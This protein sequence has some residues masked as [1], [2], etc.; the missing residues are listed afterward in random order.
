MIEHRNAVHLAHSRIMRLG[1]TRD[2]RVTQFASLGFDASVLEIAMALT[3]GAALYLPTAEQRESP[4]AFVA[5][6]NREAITHTVLPPAFLQGQT[7]ALLGHPTVILGGEAPSIGLIRSLAAQARVIN[8]YGPTE[9]T[10]C[11]TAW[12]APADAS[13]LDC[14][15]I[16]RPL[17]NTRLYLLDEAQ[18]PVALGETGELYIGGDG[19]A[20]GYLHRPQL[21]AERFL[22]D[23][24]SPHDGARMYRSGDLARYLA[25]G[26]LVFAGRNDDQIKLR[27]YRIELGEIEAR[28]SEHPAVTECA[29][30]AREDR[31]GDACLIAYYLASDAG[32]SEAV[33]AHLRVYLRERLPAYM[34]PAAF[35]A[36]D[37][38]P[39]TA[40]GKIDRKAL[41]APQ[42]RDFARSA[43]EAPEG[44]TEI[45]LATL[46]QDVLGVERVGRHDDF[47]VLGG[48]SLTAVRLLSRVREHF[49]TAP[50][51]ATLFAQPV[52]ADWAQTFDAHR[53][54]P[55]PHDP[56]L[57][58]LPDI[59]PTRHDSELPMSFAQQRLWFLSRMDGVSESY[60]MPLA[61]ELHGELDHA[62]LQR[63]LDRVFA[64]HEGLRTVFRTVCGNPQAGLLPAD[65]GLPM[66]EHDLREAHDPQGELARLCALDVRTPFDLAQGPAIR[67][68]LI[69]LGEREH[70]LAITQHHIVCDGWSMHL[71]AREIGQLY[72]AFREQRPDPLPPLRVQ[73]PDYAAWEQ[74]WQTRERLASQAEYWRGAL[75][76]APALLALP[77][78]R[79][80]PPRQSFAAAA[81]PIRLDREL[82][83]QLKRL[84]QTQGATLFMT[85]MAAWA[86]VLA[87][88]SGQDDLVIGT[89]SANRGRRE[90]EPLIGFF[91]NTLAL[92]VDLSGDPDVAQLLTQMR[93]T[94]LAAQAHQDL[95]FEQVVEIVQPARRMDHTPLFQVLFAWQNNEET[96][97]DLPG[98]RVEARQPVEAVRFDLE[99]HLHER[100]GEIVGH[101]AYAT[102]LFDSESIERHAGY[103]QAMLQAMAADAQQAVSRVA[104]LSP[105]E[106]AELLDG[107][108]RDEAG[109]DGAC[110]HQLFEQQAR[111]APD[112]VA[113]IHRDRELSYRELNARANRLAHRLIALGVSS[114]DRVA[115][116]MDRSFEL[117][118]GALAAL[119]A[120]A[121]YLPLDTTYPP[122]RLA[123]I[124]ADAEPAV[125]LRDAAGRQALGD[126]TVAGGRT[127]D[128]DLDAEDTDFDRND[129]DPRVAGLDAQHLAYVI[130]TS[131][132]T[133]VPK[134]VAVPHAPLVNLIRWQ[135]A[136]LPPAS[137]VLQFAAIGFDVAFQEI[138]GA[139]SAGSGLVLI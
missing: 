86:S 10:V 56:D 26:Q 110:V 81:R 4:E 62:A 18:Q 97:F 67:T 57:H 129:D 44:A 25:D 50:P 15:P 68:R 13:A 139:L 117:V 107:S 80:R 111:A 105:Q 120:G 127:I 69:R 136:E 30:V 94:A 51:L 122:E 16:G 76:D 98:L 99:L 32:H 9:I 89:P 12:T 46:W 7:H 22:A 53:A 74:R 124:I 2:S 82:T 113:L 28:L 38:W 71:L 19:V 42:D 103:L 114:D 43:F 1:I 61:L 20:R 3:Q 91:V 40:N 115:L 118:I 34:V 132:S 123:Q 66:P 116:C 119:K 23:P 137:R 87:R 5:Y 95:P 77:T 41:P 100:D 48:H 138:F 73:Y 79:P 112:A 104:L 36:L 108:N 11:A 24:F 27:G 126:G 35:V 92:R 106:R 39:L 64:R 65:A 134:G 125:I 17:D 84:S 63:S 52:L 14:V 135:L 88:L 133:G 93:E 128:L 96:R 55:H 70:R 37:A 21:S 6:M 29:V 75:A 33:S 78:D 90:I 85:V 47:F 54:D 60:N 59:E 45:A 31:A 8:A 130:Y 83:A 58:D 109:N 121:A 131:G 101:L 102:A 49:G 72:A